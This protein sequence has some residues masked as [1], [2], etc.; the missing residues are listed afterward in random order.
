MLMLMLMIE[1]QASLDIFGSA[2]RAPPTGE[3]ARAGDP[4]QSVDY[5]E[6]SIKNQ[7]IEKVYYKYLAIGP[8]VTNMG[9]WGIPEK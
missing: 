8:R 5:N 3:A 2:V 4:E 1:T 6:G 7:L 9:K